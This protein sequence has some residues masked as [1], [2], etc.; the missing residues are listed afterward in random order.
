MNIIKKYPLNNV[1]VNFIEDK[2]LPNG[3]NEF[4]LR[5]IQNRTGIDYRQ[6]TALEIEILIR[7]RNTSDNWNNI[8]VAPQFNPEQ[9]KNCKFFGLVRIGNLEPICLEFNNLRMPVGLYNSTIINCDFGDNIVVD[10]VNYLGYY[11]IGN[12]CILVNINEMVTTNHAKFG[13]GTIKEGETESAR[14]WMEICNENGGRK[15]LPFN[16]MQTGDAWLFSRY[17]HNAQLQEQFK[18]F[19]DKLHDT[20]RGYYGKVGER[21][22]IKNCKIVKDTWIGT[23]AYLKGANKVKNITIN[24]SSQQKSQIGEGCEIVNGIVGFGCRIFYGV[25]AVRFFMGSQSQLKYGARLINSYLADNSTI[26]CCEVLNALIFP[27]HEQHHNNSFLIASTIKGQSNMAAGATVGSNHNSRSADG[28]LIAGR[29]FWPGLCVSLRHNSIFS[30]FNI[31]AK[32]DYNYEINNPFP[33][34]LISLNIAKD[35]VE[36]MPAYWFMYNMYAIARNSYKYLK[37]DKR[38]NPIQHIDYSFM[39]PDAMQELLVALPILEKAVGKAY[40]LKMQLPIVDKELQQIGKKL[41]A[42]Q[43]DLVDQLEIVV[44]GVEN[45]KRKVVLLKVS[46]AYG[47]FL[48]LFGMYLAQ[49]L[50]DITHTNRTPSIND[51]NKLAKETYEPIFENIGGQL[52]PKSKM[53]TALNN[54]INNN[55]SGW[56]D[57][58]DFY[59]EQSAAYPSNKLAHAIGSYLQ[60]N[61]LAE[62]TTVQLKQVLQLALTTKKWM[63][64]NV[65]D[66]RQKD[67]TSPYRKMVYENVDEMYEVLGNPK[68]NE[69]VLHEIESLKLFET[70]IQQLLSQY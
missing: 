44:D 28:E 54:I 4:Y 62:I 41:L 55:F 33:F 37:R 5:N 14:V 64:K 15:V 18:L 52:I 7:N 6:L 49:S 42:T 3:E 58:H 59:A 24:S 53:E 50:L 11:I 56:S 17:R 61:N 31:I 51:L 47:I 23:D 16:G 35:Q 22:I 25:K 45:S 2:Y 12:E 32:G 26:S 69:F 9:V 60:L 13:N 39:A 70:Q 8:L 68:K 48:E 66:S 20:K 63:T 36:I 29:G 21:T 30:C 40:Q 65:E 43:S 38:L 1:G 10:N 19:T 27:A 46:K 67:F 34:S 57:L